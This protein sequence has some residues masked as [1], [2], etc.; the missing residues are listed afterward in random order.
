MTRTQMIIS[1]IVVLV[2]V[3][4]M[5]WQRHREEQMQACLADGRVWNGP[6]S[7]CETPRLSPILKRALERS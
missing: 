5:T 3:G 4:L 7:R 1:L 2:L 6:Q